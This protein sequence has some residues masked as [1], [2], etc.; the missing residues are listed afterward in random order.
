MYNRT[1]CSGL[2]AFVDANSRYAVLS[3]EVNW[4]E[5]SAHAMFRP[6]PPAVSYLG[7]GAVTH[8]QLTMVVFI[9]P[10]RSSAAEDAATAEDEDKLSR[11]AREFSG[12]PMI[13]HGLAGTR[14]PALWHLPTIMFT[15]H[16]YLK[17]IE[18]GG[19]IYDVFCRL[20]T[21]LSLLSYYAHCTNLLEQDL[22]QLL[23]IQSSHI[24][25][26]RQPHARGL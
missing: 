5:D 22:E 19:A 2:V 9:G 24:H 23:T 4:W 10:P 12:L 3:R 26:E 20:I 6:L 13:R 25:H 8:S 17:G 11:V 7:S 15:V 16:Q 21:D 18:R 14:I 1:V